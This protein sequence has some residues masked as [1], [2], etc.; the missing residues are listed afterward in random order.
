VA[1]AARLHRS[2][3]RREAGRTLIEGPHLLEEARAAG[4]PIETVFA[5]EGEEVDGALPVDQRALQRLSGT[6][7]PRGP[8]AV[9]VIPGPGDIDD[10]DVVVAC[11]L[12]DP[13]N[14][15]TIVRTA[16]AFG[17]AFAYTP[18]TADPWSPK[19]LRAGAGGQFHTPITPYV[20]RGDRR[21]LAAVPRGGVPPREVGP[22]LVALLIGEE[23]SG[24]SAD[25]IDGA[26]LLVSVPMPGIAESLNAAVASGILV[27]ELSQRGREPGGV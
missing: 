22:D 26:D 15:G 21:V 8:V 7:S 20:D 25:L 3:D 1:E 24:L 27:S 2:R 9:I 17:W 12:S 14:V 11:G 5:L 4:V 13:G 10:R 18:G 23:A 6:T 16:A 19:T